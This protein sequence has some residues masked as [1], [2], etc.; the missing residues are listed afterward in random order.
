MNYLVFC[1]QSSGLNIVWEHKTCLIM[2]IGDQL[3]S[4]LL[5]LLSSHERLKFFTVYH[6]QLW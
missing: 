3:I 5:I 4:A 2:I 1:S 6:C